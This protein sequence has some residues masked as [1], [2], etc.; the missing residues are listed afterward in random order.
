MKTKRLRELKK[1]ETQLIE[2]YKADWDRACE[3]L[4]RYAL[5]VLTPRER[6]VIYRRYLM[7]EDECETLECIGATM[8]VSRERI[9]QI[10]SAAL[11]KMRQRLHGNRQLGFSY[12]VVSALERAREDERSVSPLAAAL[13]RARRA[14]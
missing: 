14:A 2:A 3:E 13:Q 11:G 10:E 9:R 6:A 4:L 1:S 5:R 7:P 8:G 12:W